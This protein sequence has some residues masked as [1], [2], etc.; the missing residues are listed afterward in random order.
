MPS[1]AH[2]HMQTNACKRVLLGGYKNKKKRG[3][4]L[5]HQ[6]KQKQISGL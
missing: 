1:L 3:K 2:M 5:F 6:Q 4:I